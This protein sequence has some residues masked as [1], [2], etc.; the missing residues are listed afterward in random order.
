MEVNTAMRNGQCPKCSASTI[1][2]KR[3]G[4]AAESGITVSFGLF[5]YAEFDAYICT[6]CGYTEIYIADK[7]DLLKIAEKWRKVG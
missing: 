5:S 3:N 4:I 2:T 7:S 1:Y 6:T